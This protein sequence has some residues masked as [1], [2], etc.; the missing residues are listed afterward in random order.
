M[1][2]EGRGGHVVPI[3]QAA[4][5]AGDSQAPRDKNDLRM[6]FSS[7]FTLMWIMIIR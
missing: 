5:P 1:Q 4:S 6:R 2:K 7:P 3:A